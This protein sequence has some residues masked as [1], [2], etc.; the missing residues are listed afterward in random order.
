[1]KINVSDNDFDKYRGLTKVKEFTVYGWKELNK[2]DL[3]YLVRAI[4][5]PY[6]V[7]VKLVYGKD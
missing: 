5:G 1:M 6:R 2:S 4:L 7:P 3:M